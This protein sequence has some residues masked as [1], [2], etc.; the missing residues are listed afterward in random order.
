M[1]LR[2]VATA[3][4]LMMAMTG[5]A[6]AES[7]AHWKKHHPLHLERAPKIDPDHI[8]TPDLA[9]LVHFERVKEHREKTRWLAYRAH[10]A[11]L[12][13]P[14]SSTST[15]SYAAW[16]VNSIDALIISVFG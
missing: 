12:H 1:R 10:E 14:T 13:R 15:P 7:W 4:A 5:V 8:T 9:R 3:L 2:T 6:H 16:S 11:S